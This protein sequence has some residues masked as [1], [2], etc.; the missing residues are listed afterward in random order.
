[1]ARK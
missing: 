1:L